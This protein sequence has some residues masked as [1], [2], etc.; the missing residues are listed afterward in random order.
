MCQET[1][2]NLAELAKADRVESYMVKST[3]SNGTYG[4][5]LEEF[6]KRGVKVG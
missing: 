2:V 5:R 6:I 1:I 3:L 4:V